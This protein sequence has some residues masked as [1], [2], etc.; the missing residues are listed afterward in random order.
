MLALTTGVV[1]VVV[2]TVVVM[3]VVVAMIMW[4]AVTLLVARDGV[5]VEAQGVSVVV[6]S[7]TDIAVVVATVTATDDCSSV[8]EPV[9]PPQYLNPVAQTPF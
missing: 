8:G 6:V 2:S 1:V 4:G 5:Q 7:V 9:V 3:V